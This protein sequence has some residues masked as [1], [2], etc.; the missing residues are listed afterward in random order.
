MA[1]SLAYMGTYGGHLIWFQVWLK[2]IVGCLNKLKSR[3]EKPLTEEQRL[4]AAAQ[5]HAQYILC[6]GAIP[7]G[8]PREYESWT[9]QER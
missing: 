9:K 4:R 3:A 8:E 5:R 1:L 6:C 7:T 2:N